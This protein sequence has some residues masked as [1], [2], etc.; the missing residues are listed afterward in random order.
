MI[1]FAHQPLALKQPLLQLQTNVNGESFARVLR[2]SGTL[3]QLTRQS[4]RLL[5]LNKEKK[6]LNRHLSG[7]EI[8]FSLHI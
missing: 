6:T 4:E 5:R 7:F 8:A 2:Y 3:N 1:Y